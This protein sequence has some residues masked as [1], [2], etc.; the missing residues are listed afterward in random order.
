[1]HVLSGVATL[2]QDPLP[3]AVAIVPLT[4]AV[5]APGGRPQLPHGCERLVVTI[6]GTESDEELSSVQVPPVRLGRIGVLLL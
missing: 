2:S 5:A 1:M 4:E 3:H 6:D